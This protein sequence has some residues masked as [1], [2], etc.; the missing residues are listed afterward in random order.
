MRT[1]K[2]KKRSI[3]IGLDGA[4]FDLLKDL[5]EKEVMPNTKKLI[6]E[7]T[8]RKMQSSIPEISSVAWSSIITGA[9]PAEH[10]IFGFTELSLNT[11]R[12]SFP[13]FSH[14][15]MP[16][17]WERDTDTRHI[18]MN[19]PSTYPAK[20]LNGVLISGFVAL[21]L[22]KAVYPNSMIP[23]L[24]DMNYK[25][26]VDSNKAHQSMELFIKDLNSTNEARIS[27]CRYLWNQDWNTFMFVFTGTDRLM[28]F[29][30]D[31]YQ[32]ENHRF[33]REFNDY[34]RRID[35]IIGEITYKMADEDNLIM[36]S[37]HGFEKLEKDVYI[38]CILEREGFLKFSTS[39][40][41]E[42]TS[43]EVNFSHIDYGTRAFALDPARIY[44]NLKDRYPKGDTSFRDKEYV[45]RDLEDL[46]KN[47]EI[48]SKPVIKHIYRKEEIYR[49][50]YL[51][52]APDLV[53][54][55]DEGFNLKASLSSQDIYSKGIFTG[56]HNQHDAFLLVNKKCGNDIIPEY[57]NVC[58]VIG[59]M[60]KLNGGINE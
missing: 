17:F 41:G 11:Y 33:H 27:A 28:H 51:E 12:L 60:D 43:S 10:G 6:S 34:F 37:D 22:E 20:K 3:I 9:N 25:I 30:W 46:F 7:G 36:L 24:K 16:P 50:P 38:N 35:E 4:P 13:N 44:I 52:W 53:L 54:V 26:D 32:D 1:M 19:V 48:N 8:F 15:K 57:P 21:E 23:Y 47:L 29:L 58:D 42:K 39:H 5:S 18:I 2:N 49:G 56:K 31:A 14:L 55:G 40:S 45:L 59:I